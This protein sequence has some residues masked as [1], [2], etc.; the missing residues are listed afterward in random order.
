MKV[1]EQLFFNIRQ[2]EIVNHAR[3]FK[4]NIFIYLHTQFV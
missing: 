1:V 3:L 2:Y 4:P